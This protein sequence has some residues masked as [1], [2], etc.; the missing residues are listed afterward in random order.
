MKNLKI[1]HCAYI[2]SI[3]LIILTG[4]FLRI[5][6]YSIERPLWNDEAALA[7]NIIE[8]KSLGLLLPLNFNQVAPFMFLLISKLIG[9]SFNYSELAL[10]FF[11]LLCSI[12]AIPLFFYVSTKFFNNKLQIIT[13]N[14]M[15][16]LSFNICYFAQELK[17]YSSDLLFTLI[18]LASYFLITEKTSK[19]ALL[20]ISLLYAIFIMFSYPAIFPIL[21][22]FIIYFFKYFKSDKTKILF[23]TLPFIGTIIP[24]LGYSLLK[25]NSNFLQNYWTEGFLNANLSNFFYIIFS[26]F[27]FTFKPFEIAITFFILGIIV[28]LK[29]CKQTNN[30]LLVTPL[31]LT[32]LASYFHFYPYFGRTGLFLSPILILITITGFDI[33][34]SNQKL[35]NTLISLFLIFTTLFC[36]IYSAKQIIF[37]NF[38][39]ED[40][41]KPLNLA[42][43]QASSKDIIYI[44][45]GSAI[46]FEY[47]KH[48][49]NVN[50]KNIIIEPPQNQL[51]INYL[52]YLDNLPAGK[53]FYIFSHNKNKHKT[54]LKIANHLKK[55][56]LNGF[57]DKNGNA[58]LIFQK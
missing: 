13:A 32:L 10:R 4:L 44:S 51:P 40:I 1:S 9:A 24:F 16:N 22:V 25:F 37:K 46:T 28:C 57:I 34:N 58:L 55:Y 33:F 6:F 12:G 56:N 47:Y 11:P 15:F 26:N 19:K 21:T 20:A 23:L 42:I 30:L 54:I 50:N 52:S 29:N 3:F 7:L 31:F 41:K 45:Q 38:N 5:Y 48:Y 53:Y 36:G 2:F 8:R 35:K 43:E 49:M 18:I 17:Q 39:Y 14:V 27:S